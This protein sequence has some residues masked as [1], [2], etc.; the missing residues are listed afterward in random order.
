MQK[1]TYILIIVILF[2]SCATAKFTS[3]EQQIVAKADNSGKLRVLLVENTVDS[4][5]LHKKSKRIKADSSNTALTSFVNALYTTVKD[6]NNPGVGIA[7]PQVG[8]N[9]KIIWVQRFDKANKPFELYFN[10]KII[11]YSEAKKNGTEGCL[12]VN[13][14]RGTVNRSAE[15][16]IKYDTFYKKNIT[17]TITG[18]TA[19]IFQHEIDHLFG[20]LYTDR[21]SDETL[22]IKKL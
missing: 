9:R 16:T 22:L 5:V 17:E 21:I 4:L 11:N 10:I 18:F 20:I 15:I 1:I 6:P 14:Y 2:T 8:I 12:S 7:A 13:G 3:Y 19:V